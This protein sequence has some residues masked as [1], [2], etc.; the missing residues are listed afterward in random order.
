MFVD[1]AILESNTTDSIKTQENQEI[2]E[3]IN[4]DRQTFINNLNDLKANAELIPPKLDIQSFLKTLENVENK[5]NFIK[6]LSTRQDAQARLAYLNLIEPTLKRP[7]IKLTFSTDKKEYIKSFKDGDNNLLYLLAQSKAKKGVYIDSRREIQTPIKSINKA[8]TK[9]GVEV[10]TLNTQKFK[11]K[12]PLT[13]LMADAKELSERTS[14]ETKEVI[15]DHIL[16]ND[17][18]L[19]LLKQ[20]INTQY[21]SPFQKEVLES[22]LDIA[23]NPIKLKE[24]KLQGLQK[25]LDNLNYHEA[26]HIERGSIKNYEAKIAKDREELERQI[27]ELKRE[28]GVKENTYILREQTKEILNSLVGKNITNQNDGRIAQISRKNIAK[29]T[30]DK[31]I[32]KSVD[33]GFTPQ[34]HFKAVQ[35]IENLYK[36]AIF[37]ETHKDLKG[38]S[39]NVLI[40]RYNTKLDNANALITLKETLSGQYEGN[41]IY[42][43]ELEALELKPTLPEPQGSESVSRNTIRKA[44]VTPTKTPNEII[45]QT[46]KTTQE[47]IQESKAKGLSVA[48]TKEAIEKNKEAQESIKNKNIDSNIAES[49]NTKEKLAEIKQKTITKIDSYAN[50]PEFKAL[51]KDKQDAILSLKDI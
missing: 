18:L 17:K 41:K 36:G 38:E 43:L 45:P 2:T 25:Q 22:A 4:T 42:T 50:T 9:D 32:Q 20:G 48:Q 33:N 26:Y 51:S 27:A 28:I 7:D 21:L 24:Y 12:E 13:N 8:T 44:I 46:T 11:Q 47:I 49:K 1:S 31:A 35:D 16:G 19:Y 3:G 29:M 5:E 39:D 15:L 30:S 14:Q 34:E 40:H 37:R 23:K 10:Y 6:H